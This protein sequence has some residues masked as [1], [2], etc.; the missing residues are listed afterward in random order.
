[1]SVKFE[2]DFAEFEDMRNKVESIGSDIETELN[3]ILKDEGKKT[4]EPSI[5]N[6]IPVSSKKKGPHAKNSTWSK[7]ELGNLEVTI[8]AKGGAANKPGSF[9]YLVFPNE[10]R[11]PRNHRV[12]EFMERGRDIAI[13]KLV[14]V[15]QQRLLEKLEEVF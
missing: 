2:F 6:L 4:I 11:G 10:G 14:E 1:M 15:T 7:Q 9:G 3:Q 13:P 12:N 5:T 8:I